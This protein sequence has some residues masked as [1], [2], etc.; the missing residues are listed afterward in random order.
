MKT[1][2]RQ[3]MFIQDWNKPIAVH[4]RDYSQTHWEWNR[5]NWKK[6]ESKVFN[7]QKRIYKATKIG[8]TKK[9]KSLIKLLS[10]SACTVILG[11][12]RVTQDSMGKR[13][14]GID[15]LK[16]LTPKA[17]ERLAKRLMERAKKG[18]DNYGAKPAKRKYV[19]KANGQLRPLGIPTQE[20]RVIQHVVKSSIEPFYEAQFESN[21]Y[22]FRPAMSTHDAI[23]AIFKITCHEPKWV[24]D[25]DIKGCFDNI[26]HN[27]LIEK[28]IPSQKLLIKEW[29]K[30]GYID[31]GHIH[32]TEKGTPQGGIISPLLANIALDGLEK[33]LLEKLKD[34]FGQT[35][36]NRTKLTVVRYADDFVII[37]KDREIIDTSQIIISDWL[38]SRGLELS[39]EKTKVVNTLQGF[40]FLGFNIKWCQNN[41]KGH[42]KKK[43]IK[44]KKYKEYGIRIIPSSN[45]VKKHKE[46]L[47]E[48]FRQMKTSS[49]DDLIKRLNPI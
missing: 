31:D 17:R 39:P 30:A 43:L 38:K 9:T 23:E 29:L 10:R 18:W 25:A 33:N 36:F 8:Q 42:Y 12:R 19:P 4:L 34:K 37:H 11:V 5:I 1:F 45:S 13:S 24:L 22:G 6:M 49:P 28:V 7:L 41:V 3:K 21:S 48:V 14:S 27:Y 44:E 35:K 20:D 15:G 40:D 32:S 47:K 46:T 16:Y 26:D 2:D